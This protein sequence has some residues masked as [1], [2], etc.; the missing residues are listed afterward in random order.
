VGAKVREL[1]ENAIG[2]ERQESQ[3]SGRQGGREVNSQKDRE[4]Y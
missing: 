3:W 2:E 4:F 1:I